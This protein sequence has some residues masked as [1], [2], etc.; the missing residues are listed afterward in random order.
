MLFFSC[1]FYKFVINVFLG[2][3]LIRINGGLFVPEFIFPILVGVVG[4]IIL[5]GLILLEDEVVFLLLHDDGR[6]G[7]GGSWCI[8]KT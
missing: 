7:C 6:R 5:V 4:E 1:R 8:H 3:L 2:D